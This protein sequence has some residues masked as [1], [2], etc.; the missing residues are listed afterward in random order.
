MW[1]GIAIEPFKKSA[2]AMEKMKTFVDLPRRRFLR[3]KERMKK[4]PKTRKTLDMAS[5]NTMAL[6]KD[7][8]DE[9]GAELLLAR[10]DQLDEEFI[11]S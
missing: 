3:I 10:N 6:K 7:S 4:F 2:T 5:R 1:V 8:S 9:A 11:L